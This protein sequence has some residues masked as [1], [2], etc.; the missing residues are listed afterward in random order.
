MD[1]MSII[2]QVLMIVA[3]LT[4][5]VN[6]ITEVLKNSFGFLKGSK[7]INVFV[8]ILSLV[9][10]V[11]VFIAYWQIKQ[12]EITWYI[13]AAFIVIGFMVAYAAMFGYDK[14]MKYFQKE[15]DK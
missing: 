10:T 9:V 12:L 6:I 1:Y 8:L 15:G 7:M 5:F 3:V 2:S 11:A 14:L 4:V 13:I